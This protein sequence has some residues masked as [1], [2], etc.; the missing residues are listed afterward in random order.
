MNV[1]SGSLVV[2]ALVA[3]ANGVTSQ[4]PDPYHPSEVATAMV[5]VLFALATFAWFRADAIQRSYPRSPF[6]NVAVFGLA[7][8]AL[9]Y[10]FFR[11]R[12][13]KKGGIAVLTALGVF[14]AVILISGISALATW[15]LQSTWL[16]HIG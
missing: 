12:G 1:K 10:Y 5:V 7:A 13:W 11:S 15:W 4:Y 9:P 14:I 6:L 2:L 8:L 16:Q 3:V